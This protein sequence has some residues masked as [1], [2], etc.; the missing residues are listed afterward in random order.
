MTS[1]EHPSKIQKE[2]DILD[3][4]KQTKKHLQLGKLKGVYRS[5]APN[6]IFVTFE[7]ENGYIDVGL[8]CD[9]EFHKLRIIDRDK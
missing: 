3:M 7:F 8:D 9:K 4:L 1:I 5:Y 2:K 6:L